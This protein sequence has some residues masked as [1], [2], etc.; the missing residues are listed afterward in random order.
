MKGIESV[1]YCIFRVHKHV[2]YRKQDEFY[3]SL[4][5]KKILYYI[6]SKTI[7][8]NHR[9]DRRLGNE[10]AT[11]ENLYNC[12]DLHTYAVNAYVA[13]LIYR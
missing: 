5:Y 7:P 4:F 9:E 6:E 1:A 12:F 11:N 10:T 3:R 13:N 2:H 8:P